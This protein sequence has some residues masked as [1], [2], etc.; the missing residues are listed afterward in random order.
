MQQRGRKG[1]AQ[2][3]IV[4]PDATGTRPTLTSFEPLKPKEQKIFNVVAAENAHLRQTDAVLLG[5]FARAAVGSFNT[6]NASDF[7]KLAR[8]A[9]T[10]ATRLRISPQS[11]CNPVTLAR[12]YAEQDNGPKPWDRNRDETN[13]DDGDK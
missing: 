5:A 7:E 12:R 4:S 13:N 6:D 1:I 11:R 8:T 10:L 2:L 3:S 9:A